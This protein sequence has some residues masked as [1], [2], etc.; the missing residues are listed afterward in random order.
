MNTVEIILSPFIFIIKQLFL[1][2]YSL[3]NNYGLS[4][5]LLSF[6]ISLL[7]LPIFILIEKA[8]K[9]DD[10]VK[11]KMK[12]LVDEIKRCYKG[13]E[14]Y[15]YLK[16]LNR[17]HN[18]SPL[19]ALIP[20]LSLLLQIPFFIAAYQFLEGF[21]PLAGIS[22]W[23]INDLAAPDALFGPINILPIAMTLINLLTAYFYTRNG[24]TSERKQM[25]IVAGI[26]L[27]LLFKLPA[28]LVLY[29]TMNNVFSFFRM[30]ITNPEVFRKVEKQQSCTVIRFADLKTQVSPLL[31]KL[32][33]TFIVLAVV[34]V[35]SQLNWARLNNSYADII[36]R[37]VLVIAGSFILTVFA[38]IS[39]LV[40]NHYKPLISKIQ[41]K[42]KI[43][44][45]ILFL[46][47]YFYLAG[48][49]YFTG[50]NT[51]LSALSITALI[52]LQIIGFL[53]TTRM[54]KYTKPILLHI[55]SFL[56]IFIFICQI[57]N[58]IV[59][60][61]G[62]EILLSMSNINITVE[63]STLSNFVL[64][65]ILFSL[66][67]IPYYFNYR[68]IKLATS[69]KSNW[70]IYILAT[71]YIVGLIFFWNPLLVFSSSPETFDFPA[72]KILK[73]NFNLF[74]ISLTTVI[75]LFAVLPKKI[76]R[77]WLLFVLVIA[78]L[79]FI[80]S[81]VIP[82][83]LGSLQESRF[84][85]QEKL[86][87]PII[88]YIL[89]AFLLIGVF[90]GVRWVYCKK[91]TKAI[92]GVLVLLNIFLIGNSLY[93]TA[94]TGFFFKINTELGANSMQGEIAFS[95][96]KQNIIYFLADGFQGW[97][98]RQ[99]IEEN[100]E[101]KETFEGF[102]WYPN[103]L[104]HSNYTHSSL[105]S[106]FGGHKYSVTWM[107]K[108]N[109]HTIKEKITKV[110]N[111]FVQKVKSKGYT[112]SSTK[113]HLSG[114]DKS[115]F[116]TFI[117]KWDDSWRKW[118]DDLHLGIFHEI[119][120]T[121]LY[122]NAIFYSVPLFFK[123]KIYNNKKWLSHYQYKSTEPAVLKNFNFARLWPYISNTNADKPSFIYIHFHALHNPWSII[124][125]NGK[126]VNNVSPYENN[127]WFIKQFSIWIKWMKANDVYDNTKIVIVSDHGATWY[128]YD[129]PLDF[130][131]P[132]KWDK[133]DLTK[134]RERYYW[135]LNA[136]LLTKDFNSHGPL[137]EDW[138]LMSNADAPAIIFN[139][140]DPTKIDSAYRILQ[141]I[142]TPW[143][144]HMLE[145]RTLKVYKHFEV[146]NNIFNLKN[147]K[148]VE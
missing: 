20:I 116:D 13:Q 87:A 63:N 72:I 118:S 102:I 77:I 92:I 95:K 31:P 9:R 91:Y 58:L 37:I 120:Y 69:A 52:P 64:S 125:D 34:A 131:S 124:T 61:G 15:Y 128:Q 100:P 66:I 56:L 1:F 36:L 146:T 29:W 11:H 24:D 89:E 110:S 107:N 142:F 139:E 121:R 30:F 54:A 135:R 81:S 48:E 3:T 115:Q 17:Q 73:N 127:K 97:F 25:L 119:W 138:R 7:L 105:T 59:F 47:F 117:P 76:K 10:A 78:T 8:K 40:F 148:R 65:G 103:T 108:D 53:Y 79:T 46:T 23:F 70:L 51:T 5:I 85:E 126:M 12:P 43:Y 41:V 16:T 27:I 82:I 83:N 18:Y 14:R 6:V 96:D 90:I 101:L 44:F 88:N 106:L 123:P 144:S 71:L 145:Q 112:Y 140:N 111:L 26:F 86:A 4:I 22:F 132:V 35:L 45:S 113:M 32:K 49:L 80:Y 122:E 62:K 74:L 109:G 33:R 114:I 21:E 134:I 84:A 130:E 141:T 129:G 93:K 68:K 75:I 136:L 42:P 38:G 39:I 147:W 57:F 98:I 99:I 94:K 28:G 55:T 133:D 60:L 137:K 67:T 104:S 19:R 143:E 2:S 50:V